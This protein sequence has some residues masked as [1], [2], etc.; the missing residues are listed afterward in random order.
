MDGNKEIL[1]KT[2]IEIIVRGDNLDYPL[3]QH[4]NDMNLISDLTE[5]KLKYK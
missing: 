5:L 2:Q 1:E 3:E 4:L